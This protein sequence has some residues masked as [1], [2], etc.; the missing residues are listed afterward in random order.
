MLHIMT[1]SWFAKLPPK[2]TPIGISRGVP[3]SK[4]G[5]QRLHE[6]EPGPWFKSVSPERYLALYDEI[7]A[8]LDPGEVCDRLFSFGDTPI[9]LCWE[10]IPH[11]G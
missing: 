10:K 8:R 9:L 5:Y 2:A 6:L 7:L 11:A 4:T 3:R 1:A